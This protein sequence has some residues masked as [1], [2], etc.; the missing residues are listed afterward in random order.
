H[1]TMLTLHTTPD[2]ITPLLEGT[3]LEIA[4]RNSPTNTVVSGTVSDIEAL[5]ARAAEAGIRTRALNVSHAF[6]SAHMDPVL[7]TF[8]TT[9]TTL[10]PQAPALPVISNRTGLPLT[11]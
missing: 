2:H 9:F 6:H 11:P 1:G 7:T 8:R 3:A 5:T 4:A 10:N